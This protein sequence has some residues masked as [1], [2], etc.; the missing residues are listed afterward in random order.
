MAPW[1]AETIV[2][3]GAE[4]EVVGVG[5]FVSWPPV[6]APR[7]KVGAYDQP[8][9]ETLLG[10]GANLYVS[11]RSQAAAPVRTMKIEPKTAAS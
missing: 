11:T 3:L 5:D 8:N 10:L 1:A 2:A 4:A 9:L 6:L 7:P